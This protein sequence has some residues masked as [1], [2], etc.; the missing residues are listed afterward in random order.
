MT[1]EAEATARRRFML[2]NLVRL[3]SL[4]AV[5][6]GIAGSQGAVALPQPLSIALAVAGLLGFF[7]GPN[8]L[9]KSWRSGEK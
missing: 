7:F 9:A 2:L 6:L 4:A 8:L 3:A 1:D 5:L